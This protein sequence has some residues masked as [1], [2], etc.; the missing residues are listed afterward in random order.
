MASV[1]LF[2]VRLYICVSLCLSV[3][4]CL[5]NESE[6]LWRF[7][8]FMR[9]LTLPSPCQKKQNKHD[10]LSLELKHRGTSLRKAQRGFFGAPTLCPSVGL[11]VGH[12]RV[13]DARRTV[14][15]WIMSIWPYSHVFV[16]LY[17]N[18]FIEGVDLVCNMTGQFLVADTWLRNLLCRSVHP[19]V[20]PSL[21]FSKDERLFCCT[22]PAHPF[23][24]GGPCVRHCCMCV[25]SCNTKR[26]QESSL[27]QIGRLI[28]SFRIWKKGQ[29][30]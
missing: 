9:A 11:S 1:K 19:S 20:H 27:H 8:G 22:A 15:G 16:L 2:I 26:I 24:T 30:H 17:F 5:Q 3:Y 13:T 10:S 14:L 23:A 12:A 25:A 21:N 6:S 29:W 7:S 4:V 18:V 28:N